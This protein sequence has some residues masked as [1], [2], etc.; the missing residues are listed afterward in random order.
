M[1]KLVAIISSVLLVGALSMGGYA[2]YK[3]PVNF[4]SVDINPSVELGVNA[5]DKVVSVDAVNADG[6]TILEGQDLKNIKVDEAIVKIIEAADEKD[7][8]ADDGTT[9]VSITAESDDPEKAEELQNI[10]EEVVNEVTEEKEIP[11]ILYKDCSDLSLRTEAKGL[12]ISPGKFK[13]MKNVQAL[14]PTITIEQLKD[15]KVSDIMLKAKELF[16]KNP[17]LT[18]EDS[19]EEVDD[20]TKQAVEKLKDV[21]EKAKERKQIAEQRK[22]IKDNAKAQAKEIKTRLNQMPSRQKKR[23]KVLR[24]R[25][26]SRL[27]N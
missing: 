19:E 5:F 16:D 26:N 13:L 25:Q 15:M 2:Y 11:V 21:A 27:K 12:G 17:E 18:D 6:E 8:I 14:D 3:T 1:K 4:I 20:T 9:V 10:G 22:E 24:N 7:Y 23:Q